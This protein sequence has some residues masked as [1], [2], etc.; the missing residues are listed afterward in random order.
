VQHRN[1]LDQILISLASGTVLTSQKVLLTSGDTGVNRGIQLVAQ[2]YCV[3]CKTTYHELSKII[4]VLL[5]VMLPRTPIFNEQ[6]TLDFHG[7]KQI[8]IV[9][10]RLQLW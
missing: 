5:I 9:M 1:E 3:D 8:L 2:R 6:W 7:V 10:F 4:Q